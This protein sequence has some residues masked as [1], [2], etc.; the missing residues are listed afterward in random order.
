MP[1]RARAQDSFEGAK[2][3]VRELKLYGKKNERGEPDVIIAL[4]ANKCDLDQYRVVSQQEGKAYAKD[5]GMIYFET[6]AKNN[7]NVCRMFTELG[8][9]PRPP[10][11]AAAARVG[12]W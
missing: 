5:N 6:S 7:T 3:W 9:P 4:A 10:L 2:N 11:A 12:R 8:E 1:P